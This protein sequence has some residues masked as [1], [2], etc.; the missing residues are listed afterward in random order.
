MAVKTRTVMA[1]KEAIKSMAISDDT[2]K[3][4]NTFLEDFGMRCVDQMLI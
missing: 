1:K 4:L 2:Y 3:R